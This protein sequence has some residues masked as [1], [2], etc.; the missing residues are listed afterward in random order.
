VSH[1]RVLEPLGAGGMGVVYRGEDVTLGRTVA[2]KFM[3][4]E[5]TV[6]EAAA[7]RFLR[8]ARSVAT[9]DHPNICT[10]HEAGRSE[11]GHLFLAMS[12]YAGETLK[13]RLTSTGALP[14]DQALDV[15]GQIARGLACAHAAGIVHRDLKPANVMLTADRT[16]KLLDFGLAKSRDQTMTA[17]G[18]VMG[19]LAYMSPEQMLGEPV[20][21][22]ADLWSLGVILVEMLTGE[23]PA[24][25]DYA[26]GTLARRIEARHPGTMTPQVAPALT[27]LVER[28]TRR[29]AAER[30]QNA[31]DVVADLDALRDRMTGARAQAPASSVLRKRLALGLASAVVV[32]AGAVGVLR[33]TENA[34]SVGTQA[35]SLAVLPL[36][37]YAGP[38]QDYFA[39]G[40]TD[41]LTSTL[42]KI[43]ALHV[44][45]HQSVL[46]FKGSKLSAPA[47]AESLNVKYLLDGSVSQESS[48]VRITASLTDAERNRQVWSRTFED[49]RGDVVRL[50]HRIAL[51]ITQGIAVTLTP[52]D[53][54]RLAPAHTPTPEVFE[55]YL[56]GTQARHKANTTGDFREAIHYL[57]EAVARDTAY[58]AAYAGLASAYLGTNDTTRA[59]A[60][61]NKA[62][63]VDATV[64]DVHM[65]RG[66]IRQ[67]LDWNLAAADSAFREAIR[68]NPGD[69]EAHHELSML[70]SRVKKFKESLDESRKAIESAPTIARFINGIGEVLSFT[71]DSVKHAEALAI[72]NRLLTMDST[73]IAARHLRAFAYEQQGRWDDA[74][75]AW[76]ACLRAAPGG[77]YGGARI[78]YIHART[79]RT[80]EATEIL[81]T[82][83]A[84]VDSRDRSGA[85]G[86]LAMH[87][88]MVYMGLG[89]RE[90]TLTWLER[91]AELRAGFML[92]LAIDPTFKPLHTEPRFRALLA[93]IGLPSQ[94]VS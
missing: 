1:F 28:L 80:R 49:D 82:L 81:N 73:N 89:E 71:D 39:D 16:V 17:S 86:D 67:F 55:L 91:A 93:K 51:A 36:K 46:Q 52:E 58:A 43:E 13:E 79:G 69:A 74:A 56:K 48:L 66:M 23:H 88:A 8:E 20:D 59:R 19:T 25:G 75:T 4:P 68:L 87:L 31:A 24:G 50:Q 33:W 40:M 15:A 57:S 5:F 38:D 41:E 14:V 21:G 77:C 70:L 34:R 3:L 10:V 60:F 32:V 47:I 35:Y 61:A 62:L 2:L 44:I 72:A 42:T 78:G 64:A 85:Q 22:R 18:M 11:D 7:A 90:Q 76:A 94:G 9:L 84:R 12:Y 45:A 63:A 54:T 92:Y 29:N 6:D 83:K 27:Q 30:Y 65:V 53:R 26:S 37:N